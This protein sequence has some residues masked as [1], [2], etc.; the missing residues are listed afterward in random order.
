ISSFAN[1]DSRRAFGCQE[2][3]I[4]RLKHF[5]KWHVGIT[6]MAGEVLCRHSEWK[7]LQLNPFLPAFECFVNETVD[8]FHCVI[9][10]CVTT[11]GSATAM[12]HKET[13]GSPERP[14]KGIGK[15]RIEREIFARI[16]IHL[17]WSDVIKALRRLAISLHEFRPEI[18]RKFADRI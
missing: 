10:H 2:R 7:S 16:G 5:P 6:C 15:T 12:H 3:V 1:S 4:A 8:F 17:T 18:S 11:D 14:I 9:C 13:A